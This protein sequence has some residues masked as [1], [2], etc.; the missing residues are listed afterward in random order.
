[1]IFLKMFQMLQYLLRLTNH[2]AGEFVPNVQKWLIA[3]S[4]KTGQLPFW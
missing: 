4:K 3:L 1:M 2:K